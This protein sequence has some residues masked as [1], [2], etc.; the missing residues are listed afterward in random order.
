MI[1]WLT[2]EESWSWPD[3]SYRNEMIFIQIIQSKCFA[4]HIH[5]HTCI[6]TLMAGTSTQSV[7]LLIRNRDTRWHTLTHADTR[8]HTRGGAF[9]SNVR[10]S[11]MCEDT[12]KWNCFN[13]E[14][15]V[16]FFLKK[17]VQRW[18]VNFIFSGRLHWGWA[19]SFRD[20]P[21]TF[22]PGSCSV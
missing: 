7:N 11:I 16:Q 10:L 17:S 2:D 6:H 9:R 8:W 12:A 21:I 13:P 3:E 14:R 15:V 4:L 22:T 5:I 18:C 20:S 19:L 1:R